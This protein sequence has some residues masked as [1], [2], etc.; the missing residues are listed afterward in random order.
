MTRRKL[1]AANYR[2]LMAATGALMLFGALLPIAP[3]GASV[4]T[5]V[6]TNLAA[7]AGPGAVTLEW[8]APA[9]DTSAVTGYRI[10]RR[11]SDAGE[12]RFTTLV[13][14]TG[15]VETTY[16]DSTANGDGTTYEYRVKALRGSAASRRSNTAEAVGQ[17]ATEA[18]TDG[19]Q[20]TSLEYVAPPTTTV[21]EAVQ[22]E[23]KP[24][25]TYHP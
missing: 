22:Q 25:Q 14:D 7:T 12:S 2:L 6:P 15:S 23:H 9:S 18:Q 3:A 17:P 13:R 19:V 24:E 20:G 11:V 8:D 4:E 16:T 21:P 1:P 10:K 5:E